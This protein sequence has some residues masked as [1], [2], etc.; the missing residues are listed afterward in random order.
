MTV[1]EKKKGRVSKHALSLYSLQKRVFFVSALS[2]F[3]PEPVLV[4]R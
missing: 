3:C 2:L 1:A 4:K